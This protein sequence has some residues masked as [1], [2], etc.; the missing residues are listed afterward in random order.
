MAIKKY[1]ATKDNTITTAFRSNLVSRGTDANMGASDILEVFSIY[2]QAAA[3]SGEL[4]RTIISFSTN[5]ILADRDA[6]SIPESGSVSFFLNLYNAPHSQTVPKGMQLQIS[7]LTTPWQEGFGLDMDE[8][9]DTVAPGDEG[10]TWFLAN[11]AESWT[12]AGGDYSTGSYSYT[13]LLNRGTENVSIDITELVEAWISGSVLNYGLIV[14]MVNTQ[15]PYD[16]VSNPSGS[17]QSYYIKKFFGRNSEFFF[18]RPTIEAKWNSS[19]KDDR[20]RM[21]T[22]SNLLPSSVNNN[23]L[24]LYNIH[25]GTY[26][27]IPGLTTGSSA[28]TVKLYDESGNNI[29]TTTPALIYGERMSRGVYKATFSYTTTASIVQDRWTDNVFSS[30]FHTGSFS[31]QERNSQTYSTYPN[32]VTAMTNLRPVYH[33]HETPRFRFYIRQKDWSPTIYT[34]ANSVNDT[35]TIESSSYQ[36]YRI[37]DDLS[38]IPYDTGSTKSTEMSFDVSGN[39]FDFDMS[40]L[41]PGYSY[42]IK[43]AYYSDSVQSYIEQPEIWKFRVEKL[44]TQ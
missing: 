7:P 24:Y 30:S 44:G 13:D 11:N 27:D 19:I 40:V 36:I 8:Y 14:K 37:I 33:T 10:S 43:L 26:Y 1:F 2:G 21:Y 20:G 29:T 22:E 38:V 16:I 41:E 5:D 31:V 12:T 6:G 28:M 42:G 18:K 17:R 4:A 9:K 23:S 32:Y 25:N 39:Y 34:I 3:T 35:L 15:E